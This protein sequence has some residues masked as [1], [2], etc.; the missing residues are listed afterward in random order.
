MRA[1]GRY[2]IHTAYCQCV[3]LDSP[4]S[5]VIKQNVLHSIGF[6]GRSSQNDQPNLQGVAK[7]NMYVRV[8]W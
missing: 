1:A 2:L 5:N 6:I 8:L 3:I 4:T 7:E